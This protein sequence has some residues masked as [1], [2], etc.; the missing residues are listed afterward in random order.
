MQRPIS[1]V[2]QI[3]ENYA[4]LVREHVPTA[5]RECGV[6]QISVAG[7]FAALFFGMATFACV[8]LTVNT[9]PDRSDTD[10][11]MADQ[12][13][14]AKLTE[15]LCRQLKLQGMRQLMEMELCAEVSLQVNI[16]KERQ[17]ATNYF[18]TA[19]TTTTIIPQS[20]AKHAASTSTTTAA[21]IPSADF[22][23]S[24]AAGCGHPFVGVNLGGW[25]VLEEWMWFEE[26][27]GMGI[28]DEWSLMKDLGGPSSMSAIAVLERHWD[29][30]VTE[31]DLD[32]LLAWGAT[33]VRIPVGWWLIM[34]REKEGF[35][36]GGL[37]YL[38][39]VLRWLKLRGMRALLDLHALPGAQAGNQGFTGHMHPTAQFF[40]NKDMFE[41]GERAM[42]GLAQM[43]LEFERD[44][45]MYGVVLGM[46]LM[47]E[48]DWKYW[49][50]EP[51]I[52]MAY[53]TMIPKL[54]R[55]LP[56]NRYA[57]F[58]YFNSVL[59]GPPWLQMMRTKEP[60][61]YE[62]VIYDLHVYHQ[63]GDNNKQGR[64][65]T[66]DVDHC[67]TCCRD[68]LLLDI[69]AAAGVPV[70]VGEYSVCS[71]FWND[72]DF[73]VTFMRNQLSVFRRT[74]GLI[75][76][77]FWNHRILM[78]PNRFFAEFS[79]LDMMKPGGPI[80]KVKDLEINSTC[81]GW[82]LTKCP[83]YDPANVTWFSECKWKP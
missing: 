74:K 51:G 42:I 30:F 45:T 63:Y 29:T 77:F 21:F 34:Y 44:P 40:K 15:E 5:C 58:V 65:Y 49:E 50:K 4:R 64:H 14:L 75:G 70:A 2:Q 67:K 19:S 66:P 17:K 3:A 53:E 24:G 28:K 79:L 38:K 43:I 36:H 60:V 55:L 39:R 56:A 78:A 9:Q 11:Q 72:D 8:F 48:P 26:M 33:H 27:H 46:E 82:N 81:R 73:H 62:G 59:D 35:L 80:P 18:R 25:L 32:R 12:L 37:H 61:V 52:M 76:S 47:N 16:T 22:T 20:R 41:Q 71:G 57:I 1:D 10:P 7:M 54:R 23:C 6:I 69:I 13:E 68:L 31:A 83:K